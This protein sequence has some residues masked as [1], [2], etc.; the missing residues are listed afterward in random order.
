[1]LYGILFLS[2]G[3]YMAKIGSG[4]RSVVTS[5]TTTVVKTEIN[6]AEVKSSAS[7]KS[8]SDKVVEKVIVSAFAA[9]ITG[10]ASIGSI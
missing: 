9:I 10:G 6:I 2:I 7:E 3:G 1:M 5:T 8:L 4:S